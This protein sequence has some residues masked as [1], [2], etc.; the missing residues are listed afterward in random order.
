M[1][2]S[3]FSDIN[4]REVFELRIRTH[5]DGQCDQ[6]FEP[7]TWGAETEEWIA[8]TCKAK[9][10]KLWGVEKLWV[11][12]GYGCEIGCCSCDGFYAVQPD[13]T[14]EYYDLSDQRLRGIDAS[15]I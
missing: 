2:H 5:V 15:I 12:A 11:H 10:R 13:G 6:C 14:V 9:W 4:T 1:I 8:Y 3:F 7:I